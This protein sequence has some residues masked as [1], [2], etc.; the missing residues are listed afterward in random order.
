M[1]SYY[2][3]FFPDLSSH[4]WITEFRCANDFKAMLVQAHITLVNPI[5]DFP[6]ESL[7]R[8]VAAA[9][10]GTRKFKAVFRSILIMPEID[11][12]GSRVAS[13]FLVPDE[14]LSSI[15]KLRHLLYDGNLRPLLRL[16]IPFVPHITIGVVNDLESAQRLADKRNRDSFEVVIE[17]D[18][19]SIVEIESPDTPRKIVCD[20]QLS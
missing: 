20:I 17:V 3:A 1:A 9:A 4:H 8:E 16:D 11:K 19:I 13:I 14:G 15:L 7:K 2:V 6:L 5:T 12:N 10:K 18:K